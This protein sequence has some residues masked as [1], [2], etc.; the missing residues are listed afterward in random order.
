MNAAQLAALL[1][2]NPNESILERMK[3]L[4]DT[5]A[6]PVNGADEPSAREKLLNLIP[7]RGKLHSYKSK[8]TRTGEMTIYQMFVTDLCEETQ[9]SPEH[10]YRKHNELCL[11]I[12][13]EQPMN[14]DQLKAHAKSCD[15]RKL[16]AADKERLNTQIRTVSGE[17][18]LTLGQLVKMTVFR[19]PFSDRSGVLEAGTAVIVRGIRPKMTLK[20]EVNGYSEVEYNASLQISSMI[21]DPNP[22]T[23]DAWAVLEHLNHPLDCSAANGFGPQN[24]TDE[25]QE[26]MEKVKGQSLS[27]LIEWKIKTFQLPQRERKYLQRKFIVRLGVDPEL[28]QPFELAC[29][30]VFKTRSCSWGKEW[31][32]TMKDAASTVICVATLYIS[33][34]MITPESTKLVKLQINISSHE[35]QLGAPTFS[36]FGIAQH[37]LWKTIGPLYMPHIA[38]VMV[39]NLALIQ[40]VN[41]PENDPISNAIDEKTKRPSLGYDYGCTYNVGIVEPK[42]VIGIIK[43]GYEINVSCARELV[44][45]VF[46]EDVEKSAMAR[47]RHANNPLNKDP[48]QPLLNLM[49]CA[50]SISR[51]EATHRFFVLYP[52]S[53]KIVEKFRLHIVK[54]KG[55]DA[56]LDTFSRLLLADD[57]EI[58]GFPRID[59]AV[60]DSYCV[61]AVSNEAYKEATAPP[62]ALSNEKFMEEVERIREKV[63]HEAVKEARPAELSDALLAAA[64]EVLPPARSK[65]EIAEIPIV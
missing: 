49:E 41:M 8:K 58:L 53:A 28:V 38:G 51:L 4:V 26:Y 35:M 21:R 2:S 18:S 1:K 47:A 20:A 11:F 19:A 16:D 10:G 33:G 37:S 48:S 54:S 5:T 62:V 24:M 64:V 59:T 23:D 55:Q 27:S 17:Y 45:R 46:N 22:K 9:I 36:H 34:T 52:A 50:V 29:T 43:G 42:L 57:D 44:H 12:Y 32:V 60:A 25:E 63:K 13:C 40:T 6:P 65:P 39:C 7:V 31:T 61:F 56:L 3:K 14:D 30:E 15:D